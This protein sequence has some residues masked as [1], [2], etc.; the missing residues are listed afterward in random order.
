MLQRVKFNNRPFAG[1]VP[2]GTVALERD[3]YYVLRNELSEA[4]VEE[5][6]AE[7]LEVYRSVPPDTR[8]G[9]TS[10]Q[11]AEMFRYEMFN[12][13]ALC[14][15]TIARP[16]ILAI[17]DP[18]L[19][20]DSHAISCTSWRNPPGT[21][22]AP[23]GQ[24]WHID[25]GPHVPHSPDIEWPAAIPYPIFVISSQIYLQD[26]RLEDGPT[27]FVPGSHTSGVVPPEDKQWDIELEY[28]GRW[29]ETHTARAG[30]VAFFVSDVWHRRMP[31]APDSAGRFFL[32]TCYGRRDI[33]QRIRPTDDV[34]HA[35]PEAII[36]AATER[37]RALIGLHPQVYY[38]G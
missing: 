11:N 1:A 29:S 33:A 2:A 27:A 28:R 36:R 3:G 32:Q 16:G 30:D 12:R 14:Q 10:P 19:G 31:P 24:E 5:L 18:L 15:K 37:E 20:S 26:L 13:S 21:E 22:H 6:R 25:G 38:D 34:N 9:R 23:K 8:A 4:E 7:I 17:L 35:A